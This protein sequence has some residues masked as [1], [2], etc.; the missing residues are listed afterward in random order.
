MTKQKAIY[1][2]VNIA[3]N[4]WNEYAALAKKIEADTGYRV[5]LPA[6]IRKAVNLL[7]EDVNIN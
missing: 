7:K 4:D 5:S 1:K 6:L 2:P 3:E